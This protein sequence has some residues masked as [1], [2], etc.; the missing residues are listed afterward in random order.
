MILITNQHQ[1]CLL[2]RPD[3]QREFGS[4]EDIFPRY[5]T[6]VDSFPDR[7]F[8]PVTPS[9]IDVTVASFK[10]ICN[11]IVCFWALSCHSFL[12]PASVSGQSTYQRG[13]LLVSPYTDSGHLR[14]G[15]QG[16]FMN[17]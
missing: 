8:V 12:E 10:S 16:E 17:C 3:D 11:H 15:V 13:G 7:F 9:S 14:A 1:P 6:I 5:T 2:L 4:D